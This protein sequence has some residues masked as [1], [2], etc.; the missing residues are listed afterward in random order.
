MTTANQ[1][2]EEILKKEKKLAD[3]IHIINPEI[4]KKTRFI[5]ICK[6]SV[7]YVVSIL[8]FNEKG[9]VCLIQEAKRECR[10]KWYLPAGRTEKNETIIEAAIREAAEETG[11]LVEPISMCCIEIDHIGLWYRF[12]FTAKIIGGSLKTVEQS[13]S[14][15]LQAKWFEI[16]QVKEQQ[17][18]RRSFDMIRSIDIANEYYKFYGINSFSNVNKSDLIENGFKLPMP[19]SNSQQMVFFSYL[20][21]NETASHCLLYSNIEEK[22]VLPAVTIVPDVYLK[23][24]EHL[25]EYLLRKVL[26]PFCFEKVDQQN[27]EVN[28]SMALGVDYNGKET[29]EKDQI[30]KDGVNIAFVVRMD[31]RSSEQNFELCKPTSN[32]QWVPFDSN[33]FS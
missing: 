4:L 9:Q 33:D 24:N 22:F 29:R 6:T 18:K 17:F 2:V 12:T 10:G 20:I 8:L 15:S 21:L 14:E 32:M 30:Y 27:Y 31:A 5:P 16:S 13:D 19:A 25:F 26:I 28:C 7:A 23:Q 1:L 3:K 11:Y